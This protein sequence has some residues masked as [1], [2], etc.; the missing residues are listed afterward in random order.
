MQVLPGCTCLPAF[1]AACRRREPCRATLS[2]ASWLISRWTPSSH[3]LA[4]A[5]SAERARQL[6]MSVFAPSAPSS[7]S[8]SQAPPTSSISTFLG[9]TS[10]PSGPP[11][12]QSY[13]Q[14]CK[15][16]CN[17]RY[18]VAINLA[19][20]SCG[21]DQVVLQRR[22]RNLFGLT[23]VATG[24]ALYLAIFD[25]RELPGAL[26]RALAAR[27]A[28]ADRL[29]SFVQDPCSTLSR[30]SS[31]RLW[32]SSARSPS[33]YCES[34][35]SRV[36]LADAAVIE[37]RAHFAS[38]AASRPPLP[39]LF[40]KLSSIRKRPVALPVFLAY[41]LAAS[42]LHF[43]YVWAASWTSRDARL[44]WLFFHQGC[45][46][47]DEISCV[48]LLTAFEAGQTGC[49]ASERAPATPRCLSC[50][51]RHLGSRPAHCRRPCAGRVR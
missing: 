46:R 22:L 18:T 51:P 17:A 30:S 7:A 44:G 27:K 28:A 41:L 10:V 25:L 16:R 47:R 1:F 26:V 2:R 29:S 43:A 3:S 23:A 36:R 38:C 21:F 24:V 35:P 50:R 19:D 48:T 4:Q 31:S 40:S 9:S 5:G 39:T 32:P 12:S 15:V 37:R 42:I 45:V 33:S 13:V 14:L 20:S 49:L 34:R 8:S 6:S 11:P